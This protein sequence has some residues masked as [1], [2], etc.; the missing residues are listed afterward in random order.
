MKQGF[1]V[2]GQSYRDLCPWFKVLWDFGNTE[3]TLLLEINLK[4]ES[5]A[6]A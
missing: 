5:L 4:I 6:G 2:I 3:V 1:W